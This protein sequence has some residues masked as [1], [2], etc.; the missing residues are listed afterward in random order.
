M[1][2]FI[3]IIGWIGSTLVVVAY[4]LLVGFRKIDSKSFLYKIMNRANLDNSLEILEKYKVSVPIT[5]IGEENNMGLGTAMKSLEKKSL[6][7]SHDQ[8]DIAI[9]LD[10]DDTHSYNLLHL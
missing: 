6:D 5:I 2:I 4:F 8:D 9:V 1:S 7:L 10:S 3:E